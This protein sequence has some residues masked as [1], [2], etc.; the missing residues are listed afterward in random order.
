MQLSILLHTLTRS[1]KPLKHPVNMK[2]LLFTLTLAV[3][4]FAVP[5]QTISLT[6]DKAPV[7]DVFKA[8]QQ[9]TG[10]SFVYTR[11]QLTYAV[12]VTVNI[13]NMPMLQALELCF[14]QQP[15][16][17]Y[18]HNKYIVLKDK[19]ATKPPQATTFD[20]QG[21]ITSETGEPLGG[22]TITV[23]GSDK[24]VMADNDGGFK[25]AGITEGSTL[26]ISNI[27]YNTAEVIVQ[28][29]ETVQVVLTASVNRLDETMV[30]AYG[31]TTRRLSTGTV[32]KI[33]GREIGNQPV[34]NVLTA[35]HGRVPGLLISQQS[36]IPGAGVKIQLRGRTSINES[37]NND[38]L[39]IIDGVPYA[40]NNATV[41]QV[42]SAAGNAGISAFNS[43]NPNDIESIEVLK[44]ADATAIYGSRGANG[45][46][47]ITTKRASS[48]KTRITLNLRSGISTI[49]RMMPFLNTGDYLQ[50]RREAFANDGITPN[51]TPATP[52][53]APDLKIWDTT[54]YTDFKKLLIGN[55]ASITDAQ[56][57]LS[58]GSANTQFL[59][60]SGYFRQ[61]TVFPGSLDNTK[62]SLHVHINH[63]STDK[64]FNLSFSNSYVYD[65]NNINVT[66]LTTYLKLPPN[67]PSLYDASG[68]LNWQQGG[69]TFENPLAHSLRRY[70]A[71]AENM[72]NNLQL[73]YRL[74]Q[75]ITLQA[76]AGLNTLNVNDIST[77]PIAAQNPA[78]APMGS[79][80]FG[81]SAFRSIIVEPQVHYQRKF[82]QIKLE[83]VAGA[84]FQ[85]NVRTAT[86]MLGNGYNNDA[87]IYSLK[88][89]STITPVTDESSEYKYAA[90]FGRITG[91]VKNR[92]I[93]NLTGRRDGSSRFGPGKRYA[94][95]GAIGAAWIFSNEPEIR[96]VL[97]F[98]SHGKLRMSYGTT[99]ND[100]IGDYAYLNTYSSTGVSYANSP[101]IAPTTLFNADYAWELNKKLELALETNF[102]Q[103]RLQ[104]TTAYY[105][106]RSGNQLIN[107]S[108]PSQTG[109]QSIIANFP[110]LVENSGIEIEITALPVK[111]KKISW[112]A[113]FNLTF[114]KNKLLAFPG[115]ESSSYASY[116]VL[117]QPLNI[118][119]GYRFAGV[120]TT[121]GIFEFFDKD[122]K[123]T[124]SPASADRVKDLVQTD[125]VWFGGMS[126]SVSCGN[127]QF[128]V[129]VEF[130]KQTGFN[131][132]GNVYAN[133]SYPGTMNNQPAA[134]L[135]RWHMAGMTTNIEKFTT[136]SGTPAYSAA[137][138]IRLNRSDVQYSDASYLRVKNIS[139]AYQAPDAI[140]RIVKM[141]ECKLYL[142]AQNLFT[143]TSF[144]GGDP[145]MKDLYRLPPLK[146]ITAGIQ[147]TF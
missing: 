140:T 86:M 118:I 46:I 98:V 76:S 120:N 44:D 67:L 102:L 81:R 94:N 85:K 17:C 131:F 32:S 103:D 59:I 123:T 95:F 77:I 36:G 135:N 91:N 29:A 48:G 87:L 139:V 27:G 49:T 74:G 39:F 66:D 132:L 137:N 43:I 13:K 50:M 25:M 69:V 136:R 105:L 28:S 7:Q 138:V 47:L 129:F 101:G 65:D 116:L 89:A 110:A 64:K 14:N 45:V 11:D 130:R 134:V 6:L 21:I 31:K 56:L 26:V 114:P 141:Q 111:A 104:L 145:E 115:F 12:P 88:S 61:T 73:S 15:F 62:G 84:T 54:R 106:N 93:L 72:I 124:S 58:G 143:I 8:V 20:I 71:K 113:A 5:A 24:T 92:Y 125:P 70:E 42:G 53:Y 107:Y 33:T 75:S 119:G 22:A 37:I 117:G 133:T 55:T 4:G 128:D 100:K 57:S 16:T 3:I 18:V 9:Q 127:W 122:G 112:T 34:A 2:A 52:G 146:T 23:K 121:T 63:N 78:N 30:I 82:G 35:L 41:N 10:Y 90:V 1:G 97:S 99:G 80:S 126:N 147:F 60:S 96:K 68:N 142:Q 108:L 144:N 51:A 79:A 40:A 109:G 19:A 83:S 38:P